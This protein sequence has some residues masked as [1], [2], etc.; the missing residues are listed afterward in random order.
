MKNYCHPLSSTVS[1]EKRS[2]EPDFF[3][4]EPLT[5][6][7]WNLFDT[8]HVRIGAKMIDPRRIERACAANDSVDLVALLQ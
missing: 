3:W 1:E 7:I 6:T 4:V 8:A 2:Q 5:P